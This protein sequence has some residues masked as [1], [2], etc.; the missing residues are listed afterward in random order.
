MFSQLL[1]LLLLLFELFSL[2]CSTL[3]VV[4]KFHLGF[5]QNYESPS[6]GRH[7]KYGT[8]KSWGFIAEK[9]IVE[10]SLEWTMTRMTKIEMMTM[11]F[12][13][14]EKGHLVMFFS[15]VKGRSTFAASQEDYFSQVPQ[16]PWIHGFGDVCDVSVLITS[17]HQLKLSKLLV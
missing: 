2:V 4:P 17:A 7:L 16:L 9:E 13:S 15:E 3:C 1:L 8:C 14:F 12:K 5:A 11:H 6:F 10:R